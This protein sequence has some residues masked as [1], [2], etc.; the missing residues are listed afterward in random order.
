MMCL[1]LHPFAIGQ[2]HRVEAL[3]AVLAHL[4]SRDDVWIATGSQIAKHYLSTAYDDDL[5]RATE[6]GA[7]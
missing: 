1:S 2:P 3:D 5:V 7:A 4:R 6:E